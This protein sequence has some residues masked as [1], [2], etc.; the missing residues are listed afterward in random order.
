M[1]ESVGVDITARARLAVI[2]AAVLL[3]VVVVAATWMTVERRT[4]FDACHDRGF[5]D[6]R[7][8][9]AVRNKPA[10]CHCLTAD[11][12]RIRTRVPVGVE[13]PLPAR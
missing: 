6:A 4:C 3:V 12:S 8:T 9:P 2:V 10:H 13:I 11:E 5:A 1:S 7:Y